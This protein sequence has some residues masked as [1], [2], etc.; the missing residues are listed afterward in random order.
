MNQPSRGQDTGSPCYSSENV[1]VVARPLVWQCRC[2]AARGVK[3]VL[4][5]GLRESERVAGRWR[6]SDVGA[7]LIEYMLLASVVALVGWLGM[8]AI[9]VNMNSSYRSWDSATQNIW[10]PQPPVATP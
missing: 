2:S 5:T 10:E 7:D 4:R 1:A 9:G 3:G 8:Q 6:T